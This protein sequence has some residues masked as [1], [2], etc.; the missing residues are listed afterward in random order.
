MEKVI[1]QRGWITIFQEMDE[2]KKHVG[3]RSGLQ[4]F[5]FLHNFVWKKS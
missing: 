4:D 3:Q 1:D 2:G 5:S